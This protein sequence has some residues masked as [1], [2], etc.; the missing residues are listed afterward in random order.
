MDGHSTVAFKVKKGEKV[1][2]MTGVVITTKAGIG[3]ALKN[4]YLKG[5]L[6]GTEK[7]KKIKIKKG[8]TFALLTYEGEGFYSVW[9]QGVILSVSLN[10]DNLKEIS[11][12]KSIWWVKIRN[13][14][15]QIGWT[16]MTGNFDEMDA[17]G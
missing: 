11:A 9:S 7:E 4:T 2:G 13:K 3:K 1:I 16:K 17:C 8:Q 5:F 10:D 12:P 6:K 14:K 15:G